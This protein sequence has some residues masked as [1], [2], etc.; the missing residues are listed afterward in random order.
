MST[1]LCMFVCIF[2]TS[3]I[4]MW[5]VAWCVYSL[6]VDA[7]HSSVLQKCQWVI[8]PGYSSL[9]C[10]PGA[11]HLQSTSSLYLTAFFFLFKTPLTLTCS[12]S[13]RNTF[14]SAT[15]VGFTASL[16]TAYIRQQSS[17]PKLAIYW[18][19]YICF[20]CAYCCPA[21]FCFSITSANM[22]CFDDIKRDNNWR[23]FKNLDLRVMFTWDRLWQKPAFDFPTVLSDCVIW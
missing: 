1:V 19:S 6:C 7:C 3:L 18:D 16:L 13:H 4:C 10:F 5:A 17:M 9:P 22:S 11:Y 8:G 15:S 2:C 20:R 21:S 14:F 23:H 12:L